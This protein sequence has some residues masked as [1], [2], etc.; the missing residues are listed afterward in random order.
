ML[1]TGDDAE[2]AKLSSINI[3]IANI[4]KGGFTVLQHARL[5]ASPAH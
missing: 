3:I 1:R 2:K 5:L 4:T